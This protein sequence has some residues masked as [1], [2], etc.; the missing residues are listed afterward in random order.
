MDEY[1]FDLQICA[2]AVS[3]EQLFCLEQCCLWLRMVFHFPHHSVSLRDLSK[4]LFLPIILLQVFA[5]P[6]STVR[7]TCARLL[8]IFK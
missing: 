6:L 1:C 3:R 7:L 8:N 4:G 5:S 2:L